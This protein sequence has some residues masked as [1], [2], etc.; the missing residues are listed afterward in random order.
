MVIWSYSGIAPL[1]LLELEKL[2]LCPNCSSD[3][4]VQPDD[5]KVDS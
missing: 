4:L 3:N 2:T 1:L 5:L